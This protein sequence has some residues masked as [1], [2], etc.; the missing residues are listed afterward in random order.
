[1]SFMMKEC[2]DRLSIKF[3]SIARN[4]GKIDAKT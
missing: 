2:A 3:D 4:E 1:M